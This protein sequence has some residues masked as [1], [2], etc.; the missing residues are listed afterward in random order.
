[1]FGMSLPEITVILV[2]AVIALGPDK[3][4]KA[5]VDI[6][7]YFKVL[8]KTINDAKVTFEQ[9]VKIAELKEDARKYKESIN[10]ASDGVRKK[11]TFEELDEIKNSLNDTK[12]SISQNINDIKND[13]EKSVEFKSEA[14]IKSEDKKDV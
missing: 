6:A 7:K 2:I 3:L 1:M 13:V 8:K 9:E 10:K 14:Q 4:P 11:L 12:N 5:M